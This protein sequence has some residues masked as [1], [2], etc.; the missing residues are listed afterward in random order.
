ML[1]SG[2][3]WSASCIA[4]SLCF[5][6]LE[7]LHHLDQVPNGR[8]HLFLLGLR[9]LELLLQGQGRT[10]RWYCERWFWIL[11]SVH[12][13]RFISIT[14]DNSKSHG[15]HLQ[16]AWLRRTS[17]RRSISL[18]PGQ[19]G[20]CTNFLKN[21]KVRMPRYFD[22]ST[23]TEMAEIMVQYGRPSCSSWMESVRSPLGRTS[24]G[25]T[26][27]KSSTEIRLGKIPVWECSIV[28]REKVLGN[29]FLNALI[30]LLVC[31]ILFSDSVPGSSGDCHASS[32]HEASSEPTTQRLEDLGKHS[33]FFSLPE[34]P[35]L[36]HLP[37]DQNYK[38][39]HA[40]DA[41]AEPYLVLKNLVTW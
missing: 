39:L 1:P 36:R 38:G 34:R 15:Y 41:M 19:N 27:W 28:N 33:V 8:I 35:K 24:V 14:S 2:P 40:E 17:R 6:F 22:T 25:N 9:L 18:H 10:P 30:D 23:K 16:T 32:S 26:I 4:W 5:S 11:C 29:E 20:R 37:E 13:T 21:S 7:N 3:H 12:W 31:Q